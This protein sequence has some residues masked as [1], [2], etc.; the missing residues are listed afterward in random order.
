LALT[1]VEIWGG[2]GGIVAPLILNLPHYVQMSGQLTPD[3][4]IG[5]GAGR[6]G[7]RIPVEERF[8]AS[9]QIG[10]GA[11]P[12]SCTMATEYFLGVKR[13]RRGVYHHTPSSAEVKERAELYTYSPSGPSR[14]VLG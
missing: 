9:V 12:A 7:N 11:R 2:G 10:P 1:C 6:S 4:V 14:P 8:S 5:T 13:P 3:S